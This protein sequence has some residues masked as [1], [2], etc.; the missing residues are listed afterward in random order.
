M[1]FDARTI[2]VMCSVSAFVMQSDSLCYALTTSLSYPLSLKDKAMSC[3]VPASTHD[4]TRVM[5]WDN[6]SWIGPTF[7]IDW[8]D[9]SPDWDDLC[10]DSDDLCRDWD[11]L[12]HRLGSPV[13]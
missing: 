5:D 9:L 12:C 11:D 13:S 8:D 2:C 6:L 10:H 7:V 4:K 3:H 1:S